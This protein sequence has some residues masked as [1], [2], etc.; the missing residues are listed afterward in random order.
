MVCNKN[1]CMAELRVKDGGVEERNNKLY[2]AQIHY[3]AKHGDRFKALHR[4]GEEIITEEVES[5]AEE[6]SN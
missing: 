2:M 4:N 1:G 5:D 3:C 6:T